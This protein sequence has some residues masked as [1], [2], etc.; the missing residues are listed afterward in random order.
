MVLR[1]RFHLVYCLFIEHFGMENDNLQRRGRKK[2]LVRVSITDNNH[3]ICNQLHNPVCG[4][5]R[6]TVQNHAFERISGFDKGNV[7][8]HTLLDDARILA[9][10]I[11]DDFD[12][13]GSALLSI[14]MGAVR[15]AFHTV[16]NIFLYDTVIY[17]RLPKGLDCAHI[18]DNGK[19][20]VYQK[21]GA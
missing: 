11:L 10:R 6:R 15:S 1:H 4:N 3:R 2:A 19:D 8:C 20:S 17:Q 21:M 14:D 5:R 9:H 12:C 18:Q 13:A 7:L 16:H